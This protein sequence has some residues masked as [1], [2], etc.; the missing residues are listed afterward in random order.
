MSTYT[1]LNGY[2]GSKASYV[3]KIT[4]LFDSTCFKYCE[5][6]VGGGA[7]YFSFPNGRYKKEWIN[8]ADANISNL[9]A[10]LA[11]PKTCE[12]TVNELIKIEKSNNEEVARAL[13]DESKKKLMNSSYMPSDMDAERRIEW[14]KNTY[15]AYSQSFNC[16]AKNYSKQ[17]NGEKYSYEIRR[18]V[19]NAVERLKSKPIVTCKKGVEVIK[20][21]AKQSG[22]QLFIDSP[23]VGLYRNDSSLYRT[24]MASLYEHIEM[25][26]ALKDSKAAVVMCGYRSNIEGVP[27]I[28]DAILGDEWMCLKLSD[29]VKNCMVVKAGEKKQKATEYVWTNRIPPKR[30]KLSLSMM[31]YKEKMSEDEYWE[32]IRKACLEQRVPEKHIAEYCDCYRRLYGKE[33]IEI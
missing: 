17:K 26:R 5:P 9:Y 12:A 11:N 6:F 3:S 2:V 28:Y 29:T 30:A 21:V 23:Y 20:K 32:K 19:K 7:I 13:F 8:D 14:A 1:L 22:V 31:D 4:S 27:T 18:N 10:V 25:A 33:L 24:E 16:S 15:R